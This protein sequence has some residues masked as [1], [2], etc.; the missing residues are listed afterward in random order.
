MNLSIRQFRKDLRAA[1]DRA[2]GGE[3]VCITRKGVE[4]QLIRS[5]KVSRFVDKQI[6]DAQAM[7]PPSLNE[8]SQEQK[9]IL[10]KIYVIEEYV[11]QKTLGNADPEDV[12]SLKRVSAEQIT[13]LWDQYHALKGE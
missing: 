1:F 7:T 2:D 12:A 9:A 11:G 10:K 5:D 13:R 6:D 3:P 4:Y 8:A